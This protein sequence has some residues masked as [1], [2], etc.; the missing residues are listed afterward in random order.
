MSA[1]T[2]FVLLRIRESMEMTNVIHDNKI[3]S[4]CAAGTLN[5][6]FIKY[7]LSSLGF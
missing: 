6:E 2:K 7:Y 3:L 5:V 1:V 4:K